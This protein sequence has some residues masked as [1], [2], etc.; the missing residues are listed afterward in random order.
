MN[1]DLSIVIVTFQ[2]PSDMLDECVGAASASAQRAGLTA[3]LVIVDNGGTSNEVSCSYLLSCQWLQNR[4]NLGFSRAANR[5]VFASHGATVLL[6]NADAVLHED[7]LRHLNERL[8]QPGR[9]LVSPWLIKGER[10]QV[11]AYLQWWYSSQRLLR[12]ASY[13]RAIAAQ[14]NGS[15]FVEVERLC[16]AVLLGARQ[17][18][19]SLGPFDE[20]FFLYG[21][22]VDLSLR[23]L[24]AGYA[25]EAIPNA[26]AQHAG[27]VSQKANSS[28][29]EQAR[30]DAALRLLQKHRGTAAR[31]LGAAELAV[32]TAIGVAHI[33]G[34]SSTG[35]RPR[36]SRFREISR[37]ERHNSAATPFSPL[38]LARAEPC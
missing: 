27:A 2:T 32:V 18:L 38:R 35:W 20:S 25:L 4:T 8:Q 15:P 26:I 19:E 11:D 33:G 14:G 22:D 10:L 16:G 30:V 23:A 29:V 28:L 12:R 17:D 36:L 7:A 37:W 34:T 31:H 13:G 21:E 24:A 3:E 5:G 6:L 1:V 9:R